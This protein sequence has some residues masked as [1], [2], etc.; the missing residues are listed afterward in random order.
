[1][2]QMTKDWIPKYTS[3]SCSS[4]PEKQSNQK[5]AED[6]NRYFFKEDIQMVNKHM[7]NAQHGSL[8]I[9]FQ[10]S[11]SVVSD[12]LLPHESARRA[13]LSITNSWSSLRLTSIESVMPFSQLTSVVPGPPGSSVR[14]IFQARVLEWGAIAFSGNKLGYSH[15]WETAERLYS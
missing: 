10:F 12:S 2:K 11:H 13:S 3:H 8:F 14:G 4:I 7:K 5:W 15:I 6:L 1:M 9:S